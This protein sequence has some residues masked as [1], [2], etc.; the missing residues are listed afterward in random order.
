MGKTYSCGGKRATQRP[1]ATPRLFERRGMPATGRIVRLLVGQG[2]GFIRLSDEREVY[3]HRA[4]L[5]EG[6]SISDLD[7]GAGVQF[8]LLDD[9]VSGPR[10]LHLRRPAAET[11]MNRRG[12]T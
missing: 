1:A 7:A 12:R 11:L 8:E 9:R 2:H 10:A 6:T 3:F 5:Q 4:D